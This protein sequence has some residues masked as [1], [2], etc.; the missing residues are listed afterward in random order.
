MSDDRDVPRVWAIGEGFRID[1]LIGRAREEQ[2]RDGNP[3]PAG[4]DYHRA[5]SAWDAGARRIRLHAARNEVVAF[6]LQVRGPARGVS[7]TC[8]DL[9][10]PGGAIRAAQDVAVFKQWY[11]H[12][13]E[14]STSQGSTTAAWHQ[15][16]G[17]YPDALVPVSSGEGGGQPFDIPDQVNEVDGQRWQALW[18]DVY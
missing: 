7:V 17:W 16:P 2:R 14:N 18:V 12:V 6:Q 11:T 8:S 1:P 9:T 3:L 10:G 4:F 13:A 15:G 5:S